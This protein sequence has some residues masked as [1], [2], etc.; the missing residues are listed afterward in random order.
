[1][2]IAAVSSRLRLFGAASMAG[3]LLLICL[4]ASY[5][6]RIALP[7]SAVYSL[8]HTAQ[9]DA[10]L[11]SFMANRDCW[12]QDADQLPQGFHFE[13]WPDHAQQFYKAVQVGCLCAIADLAGMPRIP[14]LAAEVQQIVSEHLSK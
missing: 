13:Q 7:A 5:R 11:S 3:V 8:S 2:D 9:H 14:H 6:A 4:I 10:F 12:I 1:M